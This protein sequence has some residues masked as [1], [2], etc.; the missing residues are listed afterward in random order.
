MMHPPGYGAARP[1]DVP[2]FIG[3]DGPKGT[4]VAEAIGDGIFAAGMPNAAANG[5]HALVQ[6]GTVIA[7]GEDVR[8]DRVVDA[9]GH[10]VATVFHS[11]F[12]RSGAAAVASIP[13]GERWL[14]RM[15]DV[16]PAT[17][18]L[19]TH[20][21]HLV[22]VTDRDHP[23]VLEGADLV[24]AIGLTGTPSEI[25][26]RLAGLAAAGVT[27]IVYQP[28]G[29]DIPGELERMHAAATG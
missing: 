27:E 6:F 15:A 9:T 22:H 2:I 11:L 13:G 18:H 1:A 29:A 25:R 8:S 10:A 4:A 21:G 12:E 20:E 23:A 5:W 16:D 17:R 28:A 24:R 26:E 7:D 14:E 19:V 3:A